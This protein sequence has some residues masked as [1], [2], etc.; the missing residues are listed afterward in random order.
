MAKNRKSLTL[1]IGSIWAANMVLIVVIAFGFLYW[2]NSAPAQAAPIQG[3]PLAVDPPA[4]DPN[5]L[6]PK[7]LPTTLYLP[8]LTPPPQSTKIV[9]QTPTP[10][11]LLNG[12]RPDVIGFSLQGRPL[13][14]YTFGDGPKEKMIVAGI[15]GGS[16]WNTIVLADLLIEHL[17]GHPEIIPND[18][19][20]YV[21]RNLN[22]DGEARAHGIRGRA[23]ANNVDLNHNWP[24]R[25]TTDWD[26]DGCWNYLTLT[27]GAS[28]GSEPETRALINFISTHNLR[29]LISYHSAALGIFAGG[30]PTLY[31][32]E[33]LARALANVSSYGY[34]PYDTGCDYTGNLTDWA[35][36]TMNIPSV[37]IELTNHNDTDFDQNVRILEVFL[38]WEPNKKK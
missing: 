8:T 34:P 30:Y 4:A 18:V 17:T 5:Q 38:N 21:L 19:K 20:L 16:E 6:S 23:N 10:F 36:S 37:D 7:P 29:A 25:W 11:V 26:R 24:Y 3:A 31:E 35:S 14:V 22:P 32:S 12:Q 1:L 27:G 15:H 28:P 13:E 2:S 9:Y 33:Q